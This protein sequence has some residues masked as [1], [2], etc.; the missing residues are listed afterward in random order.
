M[1]SNSLKMGHVEGPIRGR[2]Y[3]LAANTVLCRRS[4]RFVRINAA[5][6][7]YVATVVSSHLFGWADAP[8]DGANRDSFKSS[9]TE[10]GDQVFVYTS[11]E[12]KFEI[13]NNQTATTCTKSLIGKGGSVSAT[14]HSATNVQK[15]TY[16]STAASCMLIVHDFNGTPVNT[17]VVSINSKMTS[18]LAGG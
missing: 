11:P 4:G 14:Q 9:S 18:P 12:D 16:K 7:I 15:F 3:P 1:R 6:N 5:G 17:V 8:K 2:E 13:P 10:A